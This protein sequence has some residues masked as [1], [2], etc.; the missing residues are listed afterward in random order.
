MADNF[1][2]IS[3]AAF[4]VANRTVFGWNADPEFGVKSPDEA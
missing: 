4:I 1:F 2:L 3:P